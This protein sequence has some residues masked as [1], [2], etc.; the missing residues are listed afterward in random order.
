M[1]KVFIEETSLSAIGDAIRA[2]TGKTELLSPAQMPTEIESIISGGGGEE[3]PE[4]AFTF[5]GDCAYMFSN[6][7]W[8]WFIDGY[9]KKIKTVDIT[10]AQ[11]MF[12]GSQSL[13]EIPFT[14]NLASSVS[15][16]NAISQLFYGCIQLKKVPYIDGSKLTPPTSQYVGDLSVN[17]LFNGARLLKEIPYDFFSRMATDEF[18]QVSQTFTAASRSNIFNT[19]Y[20]LRELPDITKIWNSTT[21]TYSS[22]YN[23]LLTDCYCLNSALLPTVR[24]TAIQ[25]NNLFDAQT[26]RNC[27]RLKDVIFDTDENN[28]P[29]VVK[30]ANQTVN[31]SGNL[32][33]CLVFDKSMIT[34]YNSGITADK[35][36][37]DDATYQALKNDEDWYTASIDYSRYNRI[38][39]VNTINSLPDTSAYL[40]EAGGTNTIKFKGAAGALT[41]G[42][43]INT[44]TE[45]EIA[46][47]T[48]KG[49]TVAFV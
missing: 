27:T 29:Y 21:S 33:H 49:W 18:W 10:S 7:K 48:V 5:T 37:K 36:V 43:A 17:M 34:N 42:G 24:G 35:E 20:S 1:S 6:D 45:E 41:D 8:G 16:M 9:G 22:I 14:I 23:G 28:N 19:C 11:E 13:Q 31:L 39:A 44:M 40:A 47:A 25:R 4:E 12:R 15:N 2:K 30:W 3:I 46:V 32:G 38:S 26:F